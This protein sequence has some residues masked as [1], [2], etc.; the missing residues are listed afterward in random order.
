[1]DR[2][3]FKCPRDTG[4]RRWRLEVSNAKQRIAF[5]CARLKQP[6]ARVNPWSYSTEGLWGAGNVANLASLTVDCPNHSA[7]TSW[8]LMWS[9]TDGDVAAVQP[10]S[11][12]NGL[13]IDYQ[14]AEV[15]LGDCSEQATAWT[16]RQDTRSLANHSVS[17]PKG[18][19]LN[20]WKLD[21]HD[22]GP[23]AR[24]VLMLHRGSVLA[25]CPSL[26]A[27]ATR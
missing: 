19:V 26:F 18:S 5:T 27:S 4:L 21:Y 10:P 12:S 25:T 17:C 11:G 14:C 1:M 23:D 24:Q 9:F 22:A 3:A 7:L 16:A 8:R 20:Y 13:R 2:H 6:T 15:P